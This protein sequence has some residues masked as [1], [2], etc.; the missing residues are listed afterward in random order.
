MLIEK[1]DLKEW[2]G[3]PGTLGAD[4]RI[5]RECIANRKADKRRRYKD[6]DDLSTLPSALQFMRVMGIFEVNRAVI[7]S[8][9]HT[10]RS[11]SGMLS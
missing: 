1:S 5:K 8:P 10:S 9:A 2:T 4:C 6:V 11:T 7:S 3:S